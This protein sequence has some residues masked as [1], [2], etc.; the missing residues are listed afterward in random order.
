MIKLRKKKSIIN[1]GFMAITAYKLILATL[2]FILCPFVGLTEEIPPIDD[3]V[4]QLQSTYEKTIDFRANFFQETTIKSI[5][6]TE[7][8]EGIV[9]FKNPRNMLWDYTLPNAK[10]LVINRQKAW[11]YLPQEKAAY[12][13]K[14]DKIFQSRVLIKFLSGL[15]KL[16][17]DFTITY[18][19]PN[20]LDKNGNYLLRL[21]PLDK[22]TILNSFQFTVDKSTFYILQV[23]FNDV[24]GNSTLLKFSQ[25]SIN[26]GISDNL[27]Q[28]QP[29]AGV[30]I[31]E[32]P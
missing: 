9:F 13:Q 26:N 30:S 7:I 16:K 31:F 8:E 27:F 28:F 14:A 18:T 3:I 24:L 15:G 12:V 19:E 23:S 2:F 1:K 22:S 6:K 32:M 4:K 20:A 10:K 25:I 29:P 11:L 5:K 21:T 17:D